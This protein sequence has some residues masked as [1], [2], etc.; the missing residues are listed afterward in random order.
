MNSKEIIAFRKR[1]PANTSGKLTERIKAN[2]TI[3]KITVRFYIGQELHL[4]VMP[5]IRHIGNKIHYP[6]TLGGGGGDY[7]LIGDDDTFNFDVSIPVYNDDEVV[8]E[9]ENE[10]D[11]EYNL[12]CD[13]VIDYLGGTDRVV[14]G[15]I[16]Q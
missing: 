4:K 14:G 9:F 7:W 6:I 8:V 15:V 3:D 11:Y 5:Y 12:V 1:V 10:S 16:S 13:F 2:G